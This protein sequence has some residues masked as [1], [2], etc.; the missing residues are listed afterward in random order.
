M[1]G[2]VVESVPPR[3]L[4]LT[5]A[6]PGNETDVSRVTFE[7]APAQDAVRLD[8]I[9]GDLRSPLDMKGRFPVAGRACSP[10]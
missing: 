4:V 1:A 2:K 5:W 3:R 6:D 8:V 10:A 9:H 7:I